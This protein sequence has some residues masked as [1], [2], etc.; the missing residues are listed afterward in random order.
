[1]RHTYRIASVLGIPVLVQPT[2]F[3]LAGLTTYLLAAEVFPSWLEDQTWQVYLLMALTS[4]WFFFGSIIIHELA[5]SVVAKAYAIPVKSITLFLFGGVAHITR[6]AARPLSEL[7]MAAAGPLTSVLLGFIFF[8][9]WLIAGA[10]T[11][12]PIDA[13]IIWLAITNWGLA[14]FNLLPAFPMDGGRVFRSVLWLLT[15]DY[16]RSTRAAAW[17]GRGFGWLMM[18][19][20]A[21]AVLRVDVFIAN[22]AFG[23]AWLVLIGIFLEN[24]ARQ[25][26]FQDR[27]AQ[28]LQEYRASE[29]MLPDPPVVD[30]GMSI[31]SLARGAIEINPRLCYFV[32]DRGQLTGILSSYQM[33]A[34]HEGL[35]DTTT[36]GQAMVPSTK[37]RAVPP[38]RLASDVLLEMEHNDLT[39]LPVV[40]N[41][42]VL[43]VIGRDRILGVLF[44][45][46]Y[47]RTA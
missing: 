28:K 23:G 38:D 10:N 16:H 9:V 34:V 8:G 13:V 32:A 37:L 26:I 11:H 30:A 21:L 41:G 14:V 22:E 25:S 45:A 5:H 4:A 36:A 40:S 24:A 15:G 44:Q 1:M 33:R 6:E 47:L 7:L 2:W 39:H 35:W 43:G 19:L 27:V 18:A 46:G 17:T 12:R 3:L 20:G 42:R 29:L 31:G